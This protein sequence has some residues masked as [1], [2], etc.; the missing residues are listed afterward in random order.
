MTM[1]SLSGDQDE[2]DDCPYPVG[3]VKPIPFLIEF[4]GAVDILC[5]DTHT[6]G[7]WFLTPYALHRPGSVRAWCKEN[8]IFCDETEHY[9]CV[10]GTVYLIETFYDPDAARFEAQWGSVR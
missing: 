1:I 3:R 10:N 2:P 6:G 5:R 8:N 4:P 7:K 9:T